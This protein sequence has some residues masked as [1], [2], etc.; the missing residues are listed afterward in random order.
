MEVMIFAVVERHCGREVG[1]V[2]I[3]ARQSDLW[4]LWVLVIA[5]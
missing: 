4:K 5:V 3:L 1:G 2:M